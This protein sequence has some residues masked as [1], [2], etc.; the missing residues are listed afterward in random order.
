MAVACGHVHFYAFFH[1]LL[2]GHAV[3][4]KVADAHKPHAPLV[5]VL[6]QFGQAHH[7]AVVGHYFHKGCGGGK[8]GEAGEVYRSFRVACT[9]QH[10]LLLSV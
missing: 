7:G 1:Q 2:V 5:G 6:A 9:A 4:D 8:P 10:A 3:G